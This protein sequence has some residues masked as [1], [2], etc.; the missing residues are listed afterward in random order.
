MESPSPRPTPRPLPTLSW[1]LALLQGQPVIP[2]F[3]QRPT[4]RRLQLALGPSLLA[5]CWL[6][7]AA[8]SRAQQNEPSATF[9]YEVQ[10]GDSCVSISREHFGDPKAYGII[11][12]FNPDMG[13]TPHQLRPGQI[14]KLPRPKFADAEITSTRREVKAREGQFGRWIDAQAGLAMFRGW[15]VQTF[16]ASFADLRFVDT[17]TLSMAPNTLIVI[18]GGLQ[19]SSSSKMARASLS[20]GRLRARLGELAGKARELELSTP[21][22]KA[23]FEGGESVIEVAANGLSRVE[24][25]GAGSA[26]VASNQGEGSVR[27]PQ[28]TGTKV[29][30]GERPLPPRALPDS[31]REARLSDLSI[32]TPQRGARATL[33]WNAVPQAVAYRIELYRK[34][35]AHTDELHLH[36]VHSVDAASLEFELQNLE[37][38]R[39]AFSVA[40]IDGEEFSSRPSQARAFQVVEAALRFKGEALP[41]SEDESH[42][43]KVPFG[44]SLDLSSEADCKSPTIGLAHPKGLIVPGQHEVYCKQGP[45]ITTKTWTLSVAPP[46]RAKRVNERIHLLRPPS[47]ER[48]EHKQKPLQFSLGS[49]LWLLQ[50]SDTDPHAFGSQQRLPTSFLDLAFHYAVQPW[51]AFGIAQHLSVPRSF[52]RSHGVMLGGSL[53]AKFTYPKWRVAPTAELSG[54]VVGL[55]GS[56]ARGVQ[57]RKVPLGFALGVEALVYKAFVLGARAGVVRMVRGD[58]RHAYTGARLGLW[59]GYRFGSH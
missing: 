56:G 53:R 42:T 28:N 25:H 24:N 39:Y 30:Q 13:P 20:Q 35:D 44:A 3:T 29:E 57:T 34:S 26:R 6:S 46:P 36:A 51:L 47:Q 48:P 17:S 5:L 52:N 8:P 49:S 50:R 18:Y 1:E 59:A 54:G 43:I 4:R 9:D 16:A 33:R 58:L 55:I 23:Q 2:A 7:G 38:G 45:Q 19:G 32:A 40:S 41:F 10:A 21:S 31:P 15:R 37:A 11:H 14:L 22:A 27:L 12:K